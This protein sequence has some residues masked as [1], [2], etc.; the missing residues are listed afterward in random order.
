LRLYP[1]T[2]AGFAFSASIIFNIL[3]DFS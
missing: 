2:D 3:Q 1:S